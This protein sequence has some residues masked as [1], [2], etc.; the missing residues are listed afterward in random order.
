[1]KFAK[2]M[3]SLFFWYIFNCAAIKKSHYGSKAYP[4]PNIPIPL[5]KWTTYK[6]KYL[7]ADKKLGISRKLKTEIHKQ[8][9]IRTDMNS[10]AP[11]HMSLQFELH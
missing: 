2:K 3:Y 5:A 9:K 7:M 8:L 10:D 6:D 1:M 4:C 11:V